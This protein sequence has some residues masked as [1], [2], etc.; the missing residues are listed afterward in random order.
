MFNQALLLE[1]GPLDPD[2]LQNFFH[3]HSGELHT[4]K[5]VRAEQLKM[6]ADDP[7]HLSFWK[8][9][10]E[11]DSYIP[12]SQ[13]SILRQYK[14]QDGPAELPDSEQERQG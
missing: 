3:R 11:S 5:Q 12:Q 2:A 1:V 14:P 4:A 10:A 13:L 8:F 9:T 7:P 6:A